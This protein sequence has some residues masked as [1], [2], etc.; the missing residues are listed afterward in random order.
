MVR[1][2]S[3]TDERLHVLAEL[4]RAWVSRP[5]LEQGQFLL[6]FLGLGFDVGE[7]G[8]AVLNGSPIRAGVTH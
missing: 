7:A 5:A 8:L 1:L 2:A 6:Q 3:G 4:V